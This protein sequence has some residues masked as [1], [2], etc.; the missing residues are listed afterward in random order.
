[1]DG[2][3]G[4]LLLR[5]DGSCWPNPGGRC[6][7]GWVLENGDG[8]LANGRGE[9]SG[10]YPRTNNTAEYSGVLA[11]LRW[12]AGQRR[13][14]ARTVSVEL[15]VIEGDSELVLNTL[16]G[17]WNTKKPHLARL[18]DECRSILQSLGWEWKAR[19]IPR[20]QNQEA[21]MLCRRE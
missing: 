21:D 11:G 7:Y 9:A 8:F 17:A 16:C 12:L 2:L 5:F 14:G 13:L 19:W 3:T 1:M 15:L 6:T 4:R 10:D 20:E 18:R